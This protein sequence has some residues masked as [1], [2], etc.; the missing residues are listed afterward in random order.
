M[1]FMMGRKPSEDAFCPFCRKPNEDVKI[2]SFIE[3]EGFKIIKVPACQCLKIMQDKDDEEKIKQ[4]QIKKVI[5]KSFIYPSFKEVTFD[6][7]N[8]IENLDFCEKYVQ[9]FKPQKSEGLQLVG[10]KKTGKSSLLAAMC[11][12][13]IKRGHPCLFITLSDLLEKFAAQ[14]HESFG[15]VHELLEWLKT[16]D[17]VVLDDI[18]RYPLSKHKAKF[19]HMIVDKL[20]HEKIT[21]AISVNR[22][23][24]DSLMANK[25][26]EDT[27]SML[28]EMCTIKLNFNGK[29]LSKKA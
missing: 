9:E 13:L 14:N 6:N 16:F 26:M 15:S 22:N 3:E 19:A 29:P 12:D 24:I 27:L 7:L 5:E 2:K 10:E 18:G 21:T 23:F 4:A 25:E 1:D 11:N 20:R 17:F 28:G 8:A